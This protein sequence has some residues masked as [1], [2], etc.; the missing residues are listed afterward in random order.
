[1]ATRR[2]STLAPPMASTAVSHANGAARRRRAAVALT[3]P[4]NLEAEQSVLGAILLSDRSL[5]ALVIEEGL[6]AEDFYR[7]RHG[8]IYQAMLALYNDSEPV[9]VLTVTDRLRQTGKLEEVGGAGDRGR[10]D[11][12]RA[13]RR[14]RPPVRPDRARERA[15]AA[16]AEER[17]RDPGER[18]RPRAAPRELVEQAEK[19][20]LEVA[21]DDRQKD[22]R[23]IEDVLHEELDKLHRL[24]LRRDL[25]DGHAL[26]LQGPRRDHR[27]LPA[28]QPDHHRRPPGDGQERAGLQHRRERRARARQAR[29]RCSRSRCPRRSSRSGSSP[30]RRGSRARSC[31]RGGSPSSAGRRS[32]RPPSALAARRCGWTTRATS[33]MLEIRAKARRLHS[34]VRGRP[35]A[36]H[37]R[38]PAADAHRQPLRQPRDGRR[39]AQPWPEDPRARAE[40][41]R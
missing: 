7:E 13:G 38:L 15:A 24:S 25:A 5:Y 21:R 23:T 19:A 28:R 35:R 30:P 12:S 16:P 20:M 9:D 39:R 32:S 10:A 41:A 34:Q 14:P 40:R 6:R 4:H 27:R 18:A 3:P 37:R 2:L 29:W 26:G 22:F 33:G 31:A 8:L 1:M 17:L 11:G 36:D